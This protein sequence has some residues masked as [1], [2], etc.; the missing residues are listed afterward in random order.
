VLFG[1]GSGVAYAQAEASGSGGSDASAAA[2]G[3]GS[4]ARAAAT[5]GGWQQLD[6]RA[7]TLPAGRLAVDGSLLFFPVTTVDVGP[8]VSTS[9]D[10]GV[11]LQL[12]GTYG[13]S[14]KLQVGLDFSLDFAPSFQADTLTGRA[15]YLVLH[16]DKMDLAVAAALTVGLNSNN[17]VA[18]ELGG[19][20]RYRV[21]PKM[22]IFTGQPTTMVAPAGLSLY[23]LSF[24]F[25]DNNPIEFNLPAGFGYQATPQIWL[26]G[27]L[28]LFDVLSVGSS[29]SS[30]FIFADNLPIT[31][32]GFY[33][34]NDKMEA[35]LSFSDDLEHAGDIY[36]ITLNFRYW[37]K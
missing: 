5:P 14:D 4:G 1:G 32:G 35:G 18:L 25:N 19:W 27:E 2:P 24:G 10:L 31:I 12:S 34:I 11:G 30:D 22:M 36:D 21:A 37:V 3:A 13:V 26:Y 23:Q 28:V 9:T 17:P 29:T 6:S 20:F 33:T 15:A 8:P 7:L 16:K